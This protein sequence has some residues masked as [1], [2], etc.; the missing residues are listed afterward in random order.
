MPFVRERTI[1]TEQPPLV[2]DLSANFCGEKVLRGQRGGSLPQYSRFFRLEPPILLLNSS[3]IV[4]TM[5][6]GPLS[7]PTNSQKIL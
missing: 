1:P 7:R 2:G 3:F 6:S 4:L 5:L